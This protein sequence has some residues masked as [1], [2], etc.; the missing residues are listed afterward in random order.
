[1][2]FWAFKAAAAG[3]K[4]LRIQEVAQQHPEARPIINRAAKLTICFVYVMLAGAIIG[5]WVSV[6]KMSHHSY[7]LYLLPLG[8]AIMIAGLIG[9][10]I[11]NHRMHRSLREIS[12]E[13]PEE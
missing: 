9:M 2:L 5:V 11:V 8:Q 3:R 13:F 12:D 7:Q 1:M 4:G 6:E 10:L